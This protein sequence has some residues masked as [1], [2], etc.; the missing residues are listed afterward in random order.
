MKTAMMSRIALPLLACIAF[1]L[2]TPTEA[3]AAPPLLAAPGATT[4]KGSN[5]VSAHAGAMPAPLSR[6]SKRKSLPLVALARRRMEIVTPPPPSCRI[7]LETRFVS[8]C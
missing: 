3:A 6:T 7:A 5:R 2:Q 4:P 1:M 8:T